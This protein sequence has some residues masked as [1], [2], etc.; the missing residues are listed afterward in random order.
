MYISIVTEKI[1][2]NPG[3]GINADGSMGMLWYQDVKTY[4][5]W[6]GH[7]VVYGNLTRTCQ[8]DGTFDGNTPTC[9]SM[10]YTECQNIIAKIQCTYIVLYSPLKL[11]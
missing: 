1:C 6:Q 10:L 9:H 7:D 5:C 2:S 8:T 3:D 11:Y 4:I